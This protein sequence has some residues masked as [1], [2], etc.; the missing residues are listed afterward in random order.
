M[1]HPTKPVL[2]LP[3]TLVD[4][5][6]HCAVVGVVACSGHTEPPDTSADASSDG[7]RD[8]PTDVTGYDSPNECD[9]GE[10]AFCG[11]GTGPCPGEGAFYCMNG[12]PPGCEP[13]A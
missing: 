3:K 7:P 11:S 12:C 13:F 4:A 5:T 2:R 10:V 6:L 1:A 8:A 9:G